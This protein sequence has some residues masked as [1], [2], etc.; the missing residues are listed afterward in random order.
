[1][2][3]DYYF[4]GMIAF[5]LW[6]FIVDD[7]SLD[8]YRSKQFQVNDS[9]P[10]QKGSNSRRQVRKEAASIA[11]GQRDA[12]AGAGSPFK[13]GTTMS[14]QI[15][16][17][18][19]QVATTIEERKSLDQEF[20]TAMHNLQQEIDNR[21]ELAKLWQVSDRSDPLFEEI[22]EL[23]AQKKELTRTFK[24]DQ[25]K[26]NSKR[27]LTDEMMEQAFVPLSRRIKSSATSTG[28]GMPTSVCL[29]DNATSLTEECL[30]SPEDAGG[31]RQN[32]R[33]WEERHASN[34]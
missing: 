12:E 15:E 20:G 30:T 10:D 16:I 9:S 2:P 18:K 22:K 29:S 19:L 3:E 1:M 31:G 8:H 13:R 26:L 24:E 33:L 28:R 14:Q 21:M 34:L 5:F 6:G 23:M 32:N 25:I 17:A 4:S 11:S 27:Q 7:N